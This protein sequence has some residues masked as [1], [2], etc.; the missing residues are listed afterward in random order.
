[1]SAH[2][3]TPWKV[4]LAGAAAVLVTPTRATVVM[5]VPL[6]R[7]AQEADVIVHARVGAQQVRWAEGRARI[8]TLTDI[9]V[10]DAVKGA[11]KGDVMTI[12]QVDGTL[13]GITYKI[14]GIV[15]F[16]PGEEIVLFAMRFE[17][18]LVT[19]GVGLGKYVVARDGDDALV[20]PELGLS[21]YVK[22]TA[23]GR[24]VETAP[25]LE[26]PQTLE[27][28]LDQVRRTAAAGQGGGR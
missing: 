19:F 26:P 11:T 25:V 10:L 23:D 27:S 16:K 12:Y 9:E 2:P 3:M 8:L 20:F 6:E 1:M 5:Q 17:D 28:F 7:M 13:D 18:K 24:L 4:A 15:R 21:S 22:R 14:P